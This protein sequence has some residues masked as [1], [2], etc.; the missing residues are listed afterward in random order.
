MS[1]RQDSTQIGLTDAFGDTPPDHDPKADTTLVNLADHYRQEGIGSVYRD[2]GKIDGVG[3]AIGNHDF[4]GWYRSKNVGADGGDG[5]PW[6]LGPEWPQL[7]D[8]VDRV[9]YATI[10]Y[11]PADW[12]STAWESYEWID[13]NR[14]WEG[15]TPTPDYSDITAIAPFAD[16]DLCSGAKRIRAGHTDVCLRSVGPDPS[17]VD[18]VNEDGTGFSDRLRSGIE[19]AISRYIGAFADLAGGMSHVFALDSVGGCYVFIAPTATA[20]I[21]QEFSRKDA[22]LIYDEMM[23][24]LNAWLGDVTDEIVSDIPE[25]EGVFEPDKLNNKNRLF[26]APLSVH[27][28]LD[29]VVTPMDTADPSYD[30][31][32]ITAVHPD[33]IDDTAQWADR[34]TGDHS[35]AIAAIVATLW[36]DASDGADS[37]RDALE[38]RVDRLKTADNDTDSGSDDSSGPNLNT[39]VSKTDNKQVVFRAIAKID[40]EDVVSDLCDEWETAGRDPPRFSPGY[41]VSDSGTSCFVNDEG[42]IVDLDDSIK[43]MGVVTYTAREKRII[44]SDDTATGSDWWEA[45]D[46]LR[47]EGY[48]IPRY[49]GDDDIS[50]YYAYPIDEAAKSN[51]YG[52]PYEDDIA[53][54][55]ACLSVREDYDGLP[56]TKPPYAACVAVA[57]LFDLIM[58]DEDN[59]I[60]G[61]SGYRYAREMFDEMTLADLPGEE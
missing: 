22:G 40:P 37:W 57:R 28:S 25:T 47:D 1:D 30:Y 17:N 36:P 8:E 3:Y 34:Y 43:A 18:G 52:D 20:P 42:K 48:E 13:R 27:S 29:G 19:S 53:L 23:D 16:I 21:A 56:D 55:K 58:A 4:V 41:R 2:L 7:R 10:S 46:A 32:P 45:V 61:D 6:A 5:R 12:F 11:A 39:G 54:L 51:G 44:R 9:T 24:R 50:D 59:D 14:D 33:L 38:A 35:D 60:L 15:E 49:V 26:K 31:T